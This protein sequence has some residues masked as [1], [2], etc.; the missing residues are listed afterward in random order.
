MAGPPV[1]AG[2]PSFS[3]LAILSR[4]RIASA[5]LGATHKTQRSSSG[6][7]PSQTVQEERQGGVTTPGR[8]CGRFL[9]AQDFAKCHGLATEYHPQIHSRPCIELPD[10]LAQKA[11][12]PDCLT[13]EA[14]QYRQSSYVKLCKIISGSDGSFAATHT[15][16]QHTQGK[17][18]SSGTGRVVR[19]ACHGSLWPSRRRSA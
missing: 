11:F 16:Q 4:F 12:L 5:R 1:N 7:G 9:M 15:I 3:V 10:T 18:H 13:R 2:G 14:L 19:L 6:Q 17:V 8:F